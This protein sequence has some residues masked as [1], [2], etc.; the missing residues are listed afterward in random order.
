MNR[1]R[2]ALLAVVLALGG[3]VALQTL[4]S[5]QAVEGMAA[6]AGDFL[7]SL[8]EAQQSA[9]TFEFDSDERSRHHFIPPEVFER[10]GVSYADLGFEQ[11]VRAQDLLREHRDQLEL[12]ATTLVDKE[13]LD[14]AEIRALLGFP[15]RASADGESR[16]KAS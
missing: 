1:P 4:Q 7:A 2:I 11:K 15:P 14:D 5:N 13:T 6:A 8:P 3:T 12:L 9:A 16:Q 10:H